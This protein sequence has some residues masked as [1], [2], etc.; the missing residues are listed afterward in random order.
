MH[1]SRDCK[2]VQPLLKTVWRFLK[3]L[4]IYLPYDSAI[5]LIGMLLKESESF[6]KKDTCTPMY[7]STLFTVMK[8]WKQ[9]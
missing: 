8:L 5:S 1:C 7:I 6:S 2:L 3:K 4:K 9:P